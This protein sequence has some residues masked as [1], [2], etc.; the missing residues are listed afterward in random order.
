L[1][2]VSLN[3]VSGGAKVHVA[4]VMPPAGDVPPIE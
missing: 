2:T 4:D 1:R 3:K